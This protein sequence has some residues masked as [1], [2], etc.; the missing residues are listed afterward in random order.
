[1]KYAT[2]TISMDKP[3]HQLDLNLLRVL[4][5]LHRC[6]SVTLA[7]RALAL[8]QPATSNA[9]ARLRRHF[10]DPLYVR[11]PTGL[12]ATALALRVAPA[13]AQR[14]AQLEADLALPAAF[15][16][17]A[18]LRTWRLSLSDLGEMVFLPAVTDALQRDAP[19]TRLV[20]AAVSAAELDDALARR[21]LDLAIGILAPRQRGV[22]STL[23]FSEGYVALSDAALPPQQR[24]LAGLQSLG[25]VVASPTATFHGG[26]EASL[27]QAGLG[28]RIV[29]Q[30][31]HFAAMPDLVR[32]GAL[33]AIVP[34]TWAAMVCARAPLVAWPLPVELPRYDV[35]LVWHAASEGDAAVDWLRATVLRLFKRPS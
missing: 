7:G 5:A 4:V 18:S 23:L 14:L 16:P 10:D 15:D 12:A 22:R 25:L 35:K 27:R 29:M 21:E 17:A 3:F 26:I 13:V 20:N 9:L 6:R 8:S 1:M 34:S 24:N 33:A 30:T 19:H 2:F 28:D 31:R 32:A 11:T